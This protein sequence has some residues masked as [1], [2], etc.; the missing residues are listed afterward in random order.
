MVKTYS[1][2]Q[3]IDNAAGSVKLPIPKGGEYEKIHT[4]LNSEQ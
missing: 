1:I 3:P 4:H 2:L